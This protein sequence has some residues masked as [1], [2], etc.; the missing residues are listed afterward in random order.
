MST[1]SSGLFSRRRREQSGAVAC[2]LQWECPSC[3]L[4]LLRVGSYLFHGSH[5]LPWQYLAAL[6]HEQGSQPMRCVT[7]L[8]AGSKPAKFP[9]SDMLE[10]SSSLSL[11][12]RPA[13]TCQTS[14]PFLTLCRQQHHPFFCPLESHANVT[15]CHCISACCNEAAALCVNQRLREAPSSCMVQALCPKAVC[16]AWAVI[17]VGNV[18]GNGGPGC[19]AIKQAFWC[20]E[21]LA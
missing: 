1:S 19:F 12:T 6:S 20:G 13:P 7:L 14:L 5:S 18:Y 11:G 3:T 10:A 16:Q 8:A 9:Q 17:C 21:Y 15:A 4:T 2:P